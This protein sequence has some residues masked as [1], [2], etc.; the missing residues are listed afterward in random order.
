VPGCRGCCATALLHNVSDLAEEGVVA[1]EG[2]PTFRLH[3]RPLVITRR[4]YAETWWM[5]SR[6]HRPASIPRAEILG[7]GNALSCSES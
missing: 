7:F 4:P 5:S 3:P 2:R 1:M 6:T